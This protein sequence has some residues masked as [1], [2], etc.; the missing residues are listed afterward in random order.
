MEHH[1]AMVSL[2]ATWASTGLIAHSRA[3]DSS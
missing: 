1:T 2:D 3:S